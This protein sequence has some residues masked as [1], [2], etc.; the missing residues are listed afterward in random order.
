M[1]VKWEGRRYKI[2]KEKNKERKEGRKKNE[3]K[4]I[5][6]ES[7]KIGYGRE[8]ERQKEVIDEP[9]GLFVSDE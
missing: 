6:E 2:E 7:Y 9:K 4:K 1:T 5:W 8:K 3:G